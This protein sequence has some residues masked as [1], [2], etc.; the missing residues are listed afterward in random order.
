MNK[1]LLILLFSVV[2]LSSC[3]KG[4]DAVAEERTQAEI[5]DK[6]IQ[7]YIAGT[8]GLSAVAKRIDSAGI[9]TGV[10]YVELAPGSGNDLFTSSTRI[11]IDYTSKKLLTGEVFA[12]SN[13]FH[14]SF[15]LGEVLRAWKLGIP[16][17]KKGGKIRIIAASRYAYGPYD[18][19]E[20]NLP[21]NSVV[22]FEIELL[23]V[24]N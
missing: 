3:K 16:Q 11:T 8:P 9:A 14:P 4:Y 10:Y 19:P 7:D 22:D 6:I 24:T 12:R 17:I 15:T 23:D 21:K 20:I 2:C 13:N 18:Q 1:I 5:D